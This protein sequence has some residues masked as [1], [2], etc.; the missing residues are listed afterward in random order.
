MPFR[1][2]FGFGSYAHCLTESDLFINVRVHNTSLSDALATFLSAPAG[3]TLHQID[4]CSGLNCS[5][6]CPAP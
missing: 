3:Y 1:I 2:S 4:D 6:G 5:E